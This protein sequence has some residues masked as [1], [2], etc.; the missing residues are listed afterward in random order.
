MRSGAD[1]ANWRQVMF[2]CGILSPLFYLATDRLAGRLLNGYSF[3]AQ[4]MSELSA[5]GSPTRSLVVSLNLVAALLMIVFGAGVWRVGG[6]ALLPRITGWLLI[7]NAALGLIGTIFFPTRFGVRPNFA[8]PGVIIMFFSVV[9]SVLAM[10]FGA[11]AFSGWIRVLSIAIPVSYVLLAVLRLTTGASS[12]AGQAALLVGA[13]ERTMVY[14]FL[15]WVMALAIHLL[16]SRKG[17][18]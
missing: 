17:G 8:S 12:P 14:S 5:T 16:L 15:L 18:R 1:G 4:S 9:C 11:A 2:F 7:G 13:Q 3:A 10:M 6:Q